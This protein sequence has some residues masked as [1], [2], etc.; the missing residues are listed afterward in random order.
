MTASLPEEVR[1]VF[2]RFITTEYTTI[3]RRG[4]PIAWPVT[5]YYEPGGATIDITTGVGYPKKALDA[6]RNPR[7]SLLFSDP[8]GS[9]ISSGTA[10]PGP[11]DGRGRR[12]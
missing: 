3:D 5:P 7:V 8:T 4:Q 10:G 11:G 6:K 2:S 1:E 9:G 12:P